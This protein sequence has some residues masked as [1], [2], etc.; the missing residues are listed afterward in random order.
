MALGASTAE[1]QRVI[2]REGLM[3]TTIGLGCGLILALA[4]GRVLTGFLYDVRSVD[5]AVLSIAMLLL[6]AVSMLAC[7][8]PARE[9]P[10]VDPM[11]AL[12]YE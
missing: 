1:T 4:I 3:V 6:T 7:Y 12:H 11:I 8:L 10:R 2:L 9:A 5:A